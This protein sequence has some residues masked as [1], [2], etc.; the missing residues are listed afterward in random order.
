MY[1]PNIWLLSFSVLS[2]IVIYFPKNGQEFFAI[3]SVCFFLF[4][5]LQENFQIDLT[6]EIG[7]TQFSGIL[8]FVSFISGVLIFSK[9]SRLGDSGLEIVGWK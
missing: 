4:L 8:I 1:T 7:T 9:P 3:F 6:S 2:N 5:F